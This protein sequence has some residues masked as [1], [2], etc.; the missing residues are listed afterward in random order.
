ML[1]HGV[2]RAA[3]RVEKVPIAETFFARV[4]IAATM[5]CPP[6]VRLLIGTSARPAPDVTQHRC[7][8]VAIAPR[9]LHLARLSPCKVAQRLGHKHL[10]RFAHV[11]RF[12]VALQL[13]ARCFG[14]CL[15]FGVDGAAC[16]DLAHN[17]I[18]FVNN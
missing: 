18:A 1:K 16:V 7:F 14:W 6:V 12:S 8:V 17:L 15:A 2:L 10:A 5:I 13:L 11:F 4:A 9:P 3:Y